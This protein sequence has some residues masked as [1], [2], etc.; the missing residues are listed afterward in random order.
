MIP[1]LVTA[2]LSLLILRVPKEMLESLAISFPELL[3]F[4]KITIEMIIYLMNYPLYELINHKM[5]LN[6]DTMMRM[7][8]VT[9]ILM[10]Q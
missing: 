4:I 9:M 5:M 6:M 1:N 7:M 3:E 10:M 8:I 2:Y